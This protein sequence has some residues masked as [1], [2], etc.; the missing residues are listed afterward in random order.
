M[1]DARQAACTKPI[2]LGAA[3]VKIATS[4]L[5]SALLC[6]ALPAFAAEESPPPAEQ[7]AIDTRIGKLTFESG[8]PPRRR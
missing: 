1:A 2:I 8:Y 7:T 3:P 5:P 4:L 6:G